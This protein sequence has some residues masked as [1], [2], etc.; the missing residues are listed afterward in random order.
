MRIG[1]TGANGTLGKAL[2]KALKAKGA[3]VI[4][5]THGSIK[6]KPG[7]EI[8]PDEWIQWQWGKENALRQI[9]GEIDILILNHGINPKSNQSTKA[10]NECLEVNALSTWK[11]IEQ[12]E[13]VKIGAKILEY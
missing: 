7:S 13:N 6:N 8:D 10:L 11:L 4:G 2:I 1:I 5:L 12:F 3:F 9:F